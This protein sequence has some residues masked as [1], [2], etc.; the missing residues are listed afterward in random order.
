MLYNFIDYYACI[1]QTRHMH[2]HCVFTLILA[3]YTDAFSPYVHRI[4]ISLAG[5]PGISTGYNFGA[6][7]GAFDPKQNRNAHFHNFQEKWLN[8]YQRNVFGYFLE[9]PEQIRKGVKKGFTEAL[10]KCFNKGLKKGFWKVLKTMFRTVL[11]E[12]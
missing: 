6:R 12:R 9:I 1:I 11:K 4:P 5:D 2:V 3:T 10:T 7:G 8:K